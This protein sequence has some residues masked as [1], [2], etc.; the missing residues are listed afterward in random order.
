M[1]SLAIVGLFLGIVVTERARSAEELARREAELRT[2]FE[3]APDGLVTLDDR[4][5]VT[6]ANAMAARILGRPAADLGGTPLASLLPGLPAL[7]AR[8]TAARLDAVGPGGTRLPLEVSIA[9]AGGTGVHIVTLRD[10]SQRIA[11]EERLRAKEEELTGVLRFAAAGQ[12]ASSLAH[13]L[14]QP[15]YALATYVQSCQLLAADPAGDRAL[16]SE[17]MGKAVS[18]VGRA[19]DVVKRLREFFQTGGTRLE[20]IPVRRLLE[21][22]VDASRRRAERHRVAVSIDGEGADEV[23][24]DALQLEIVLHNLVG[25]AIDAIEAGR[26]ER[27]EIR[28]SARRRDASV[29]IRCEDTGPGIAPEVADRLFQPFTTTKPEGMGLGLS[30]A[31][32]IVEA[33]GGRLWA[34]PVPTGSAFCLTLPGTAGTNDA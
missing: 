6:S 24:C 15:L 9:P 28:L 20:R 21:T 25:N 3:T 11:G 23:T 17:L 31:S 30:I 34:E 22:A 8:R 26:C 4:G 12:V 27:R 10:I 7:P 5:R 18:E 33:H 14:N 32:Y 13:E 1:L 16:L 29:E 2:T 19:G